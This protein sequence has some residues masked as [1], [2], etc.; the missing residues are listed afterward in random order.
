MGLLRSNLA[1]LLLVISTVLMFGTVLVF[2]IAAWL[3]RR[4]NDRKAAKWHALETR[5]LALLYAIGEGKLAPDELH[6]QVSKRQE[7]V[8]VDFLYKQVINNHT[9]DWQRLCRAVATPYLGTLA[10]RVREGDVWQRARAVRTLA[11]LAGPEHGDAIIAALDDPEV[12]VAQTAARAYARLGLGPIDPLL[13][14]LDR[15]HPWDRRL[16]RHTLAL[17]GPKAGPSLHRSLADPALP[18]H[19]RLSCADTLAAL[20]YEGAND[21]ALQ[22]LQEETDPEL[23]LAALRLFR[24]A[25]TEAHREGVRALRNSADPVLQGQAVGCLARIG[26]GEDVAALAGALD[27]SSPWVRFNAARGLKLRHD[28]VPPLATAGMR[29][30]DSPCS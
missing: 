7:L 11:E 29:A 14:R 21:T 12:H 25:V 10:A 26:D 15:Y 18:V 13:E 30:G 28:A 3:L 6:A 23:R 24:G 20:K 27:D 22:L 2:L 4:A 16:L 17:L 5:W 1:M 8:L 9:P 19:V